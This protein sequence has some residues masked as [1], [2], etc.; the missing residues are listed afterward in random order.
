MDSHL[1]FYIQKLTFGFH[2]IEHNC[3][4]RLCVF[5]CSCYLVFYRATIKST[6]LSTNCYEGMRNTKLSLCIESYL[7]I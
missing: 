6:G 4:L 2:I 3:V 7:F 5:V 1:V